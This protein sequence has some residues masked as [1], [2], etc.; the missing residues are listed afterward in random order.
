MDTKEKII[1]AAAREFA[2]RGY[3]RTT[4]RNISKRAGINHA[5]INYHFS[6]K[7]HLYLEVVSYLFEKTAEFDAPRRENLDSVETWKTAIMEHVLMIITNISRP[8]KLMRWKHNIIFREMVEPS[9]M[10]PVFFEK[11]IKPQ[12]DNLAYY[13]KMGLPENVTKKEL[14]YCLLSVISQCV[15]YEQNREFVKLTAGEGFLSEDILEKLASA[16]TE[17]TCRNLQFKTK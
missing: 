14:D 11:F 17:N 2:E 12:I 15:F 1:N 6:T 5:G 10:L 13:L 16:I 7:E 4:M 3:L 8:N 9:K